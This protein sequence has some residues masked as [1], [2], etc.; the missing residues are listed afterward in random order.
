MWAW[1]GAELLHKSKRW[2][3]LCVHAA[4]LLTGLVLL[5]FNLCLEIP[6]FFANSE[7][8]GGAD[9]GATMFECIQDK[10]SPLWMKRLPFFFCYFFAS[11]WASVALTYRFLIKEHSNSQHS[12]SQHSS[13]KDPA[14]TA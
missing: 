9:G 14:K 6:H 5:G 1:D 11:S 10:Q 13:S 7:R 8:S 3:D 4:L 2:G 12:S